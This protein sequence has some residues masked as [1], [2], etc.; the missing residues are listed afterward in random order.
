MP[1]MRAAVLTGP[2]AFEVRDVPLPAP[3]PS[4]VLVRV[5]N[6]GICGSD[7]HFYRGDF[8]AMPNLIMGHEIAGEVAEVGEGVTS[9]TAGDRVAVEPLLVCNHC[10]YCRSGDYQLC[11]E[12]KLLGTFA[13]GGFAEYVCVPASTLYRLPGTLPFDAG[14]LV[15][16]IA[17]CVHG[18]RLVRFEGGER[19]LVLGAGTIGL[20][21]ILTARALGASDVAITARHPHQK[22]AAEALG[23][24][25]FDAGDAASLS[26][27]TGAAPPDIVVETVGGRANTFEQAIQLVRAGGRVSL[28]GLFTGPVSLNATLF[29]LKEVAAA[30]SITYGR[31]GVRADFDHA[32]DIVRRYTEDVRR[33]ITHR[34]TLDAI[35]EGF[36]AA[37]DKSTGSLKVT[38]EP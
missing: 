16:P 25:V 14:A 11:P 13:P 9:V 17:V 32:V 33:L 38:V 8:P 6:C 15:E 35:G 20:A 26:Q 28:L 22:A 19:V 12:R 18:L 24:R 5:R 27:A 2:R 37:A 10:G 36:A 3:G 1:T 30:G 21:T 34:V 4:E 23:A 31:P 7:L 29:L